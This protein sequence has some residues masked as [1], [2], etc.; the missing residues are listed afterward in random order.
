M[1]C[2]LVHSR[3]ANRAWEYTEKGGRQPLAGKKRSQGSAQGKQPCWKHALDITN[4]G[5]SNW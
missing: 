4:L 5:G 1:C 3:R 2:L